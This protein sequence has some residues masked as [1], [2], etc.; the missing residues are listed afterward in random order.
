MLNEC[1]LTCNL[2]NRKKDRMVTLAMLK[3]PQSVASDIH[4]EKQL[5]HGTSPDVVDAI[6]KQNFD[7]RVCGKK[8]TKYGKGSY[9]ATNASYS[10]SYADSGSDGSRF[11]FLA[12]VLVGSF[13]K[14]EPG[15]QRPPNK[16]PSN[17]SSDL[18]DSCVDNEC[19]PT[20]FVIFDSDQFYPEYVIKYFTLHQDQILLTPSNFKPRTT[21]STEIIKRPIPHGALIGS[22]SILQKLV[23]LH[24]QGLTANQKRA[25]SHSATNLLQPIEASRSGPSGLTANL[26]DLNR[27]PSVNRAVSKSA[28]K[29]HQPLSAPRNSQVLKASPKSPSTSLSSQKALSYS[30]SS[31]QQPIALPRGSQGL[32]PN[33]KSP[34][35]N[36][37]AIR[38]LPRSSSNLQEPI[39]PSTSS[40]GGA[41][42]SSDTFTPSDCNTRSRKKQKN[43][44]K[45]TKCFI[46]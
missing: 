44:S 5:F 30:A 28:S 45:S 18:Y 11:M 6:C 7:W 33:S 25:L 41:D 39:K 9:F 32:R 23:L 34:S 8:G 35:P 20:I 17:P 37:S 38:S 13:I 16:D 46:L 14:G 15:Y 26:V 31:L 24:P 29:L 12:R 21:K 43:D 22:T 1:L 40:K 42:G 19:N 10:H 2:I 3:N 27:S 4:N 36:L